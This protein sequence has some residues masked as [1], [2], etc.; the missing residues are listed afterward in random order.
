[1]I[2]IISNEIEE[3]WHILICAIRLHCFLLSWLTP[4]RC[5]LEHETANFVLGY[6]PVLSMNKNEYKGDVRPSC[7]HVDQ[8]VNISRTVLFMPKPDQ[9]CCRKMD[10]RWIWGFTCCFP[11]KIHKNGMMLIL[12]T[13]NRCRTA[14][15]KTNLED[16]KGV[17]WCPLYN[18]LFRKG[19]NLAHWR[20]GFVLK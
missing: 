12:I 9:S 19:M 3:K 2:L 14:Q 17:H 20:W 6:E 1:M 5:C 7:T 8:N 16:L 15:L 13:L 18:R 4:Y 10:K 11:C